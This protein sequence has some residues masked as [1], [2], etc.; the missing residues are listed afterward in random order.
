MYNLYSSN[1][2]KMAPSRSLPHSTRILASGCWKKGIAFLDVVL[3]L[4]SD[5]SSSMVVGLHNHSRSLKCCC[6]SSFWISKIACGVSW[7]TRFPP[8]VV[9]LY[10]GLIT[11]VRNVFITSVDSLPPQFLIYGVPPP[12][13]PPILPLQ[14]LL[15]KNLLKRPQP[16]HADTH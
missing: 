4:F 11:F 15:Q 8:Q 6:G 14:N 12:I 13:L 3:L 7:I 10:N 16:F 2:C 1:Q 9:L 5:G